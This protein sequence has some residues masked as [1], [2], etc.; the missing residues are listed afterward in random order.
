MVEMGRLVTVSLFYYLLFCYNYIHWY[1]MRFSGE[2]G[3]DL[4]IESKCDF[5]G[6]GSGKESIIVSATSAMTIIVEI[7]F[8]T[9][10]YD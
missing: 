7:E 6:M 8:T 2:F 5:S 10:H 1:I 9:R 3:V 4:R